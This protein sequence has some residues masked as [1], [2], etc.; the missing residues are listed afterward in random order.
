MAEKKPIEAGIISRIAGAVKGAL[1]A[2]SG[3]G[4]ISENQYDSG[5]FGPNRP[6]DVMVPKQD[7]AQI[8]GRRFDYQVGTN[9]VIT[10][11]S[12]EGVSFS[13]LRF[14]ADSCDVLRLVIETRKDQMAKLKWAITPIDDTKD[15][16]ARCKEIQDFL[17][18]PD[19]EHDWDTWLR[20]LLEDMFVIDAPTLYVRRTV[21]G[22]LYALEPI[23]GDTIK[24]LLDM[25][26]RTPIPPNHAYQQIIKGIVASDYTTEEMIYRPRNAR[27]HKV[28]GF[29]PVEQIL[30]TVNTALRR[31][32]HKL[33]FYTEGNIPEAIVGT[34]DTWNPDQIRQFQELWDS[35]NEGNTAERR[36][37]K[38]VP[39]KLDIHMIKEDV[40]KDAFDEWLARIVCFCFSIEPTA[41]VQHMNRAT[42]ETAREAALTE[43]LAPIM[44]WVVNLINYIIRFVFGYTDLQFSWADEKVQDPLQRANV[45]KIYLDG[46]VIT[47][48]EVRGDLGLEPLTDEQLERISAAKQPPPVAL[49]PSLEVGQEGAPGA[50]PTEDG[51]PPA[52]APPKP[53]A[54]P[55]AGKQD[56]KGEVAK[57]KKSKPG[58]I[59]PDRASIVKIQNRIADFWTDYLAK[60]SK[61]VAG[62]VAA[63]LKKADE[64]ED[65]TEEQKAANKKKAQQI[66]SDLDINFD[67]SIDS[68][69]ALLAVAANDGAEAAYDEL[70]MDA[71]EVPSI[72]DWAQD[73]AAEMVGKKWVNGELVDNPDAQWVITDSTRDMLKGIIASSIDEGAT[74]DEL[75][76]NLAESFGFSPE[77]AQA[78]A[79]T[80]TRRADSAGQVA[81][82]K[83]SGVVQKKAWST[84]QDDKVSDECL[85]NEAA[86]AIPLDDDFPS[87][88]QAPPA[89]PACRCSVVAVL[90]QGTKDQDQEASDEGEEQ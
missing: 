37:M 49:V 12:D 60:K 25:Q 74:T 54:K 8:V 31:S 80:E 36:H 19:R 21:G 79:R 85:K 44:Q 27:T 18:F 78:I 22:Q 33:Q 61:Q 24:R 67:D 69:T 3:S 57:A 26:G 15:P 82:Y 9:R 34:P 20:M 40:L 89:H 83:E 11:R 7:E 2:F 47:P 13:Q 59:D 81:A 43:G 72:A 23:S 71:E 6:L 84:A 32:V 65:L 41:F 10:P 66:A 17:Q 50:A 90:D 46:G 29:S 87:G 45:H 28:Y 4:E 70:S 58:P 62:Q 38:F 42:A 39:G 16:D 73:R 52:N 77:R 30:I 48:D 64:G 35:L 51:K 63:E 88:E 55:A 1:A 5:I 86:G 14:L 75:A 56:E 53:A 76:D 68:M